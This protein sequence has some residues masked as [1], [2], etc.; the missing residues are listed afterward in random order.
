MMATLAFN[1]S[2]T[3]YTVPDKTENNNDNDAVGGKGD[4]TYDFKDDD[5]KNGKKTSPA[6]IL[7]GANSTL[8]SGRL[9]LDWVT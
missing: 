9:N 6:M 5:A 8:A 7:S 1:K 4:T 2:N 3:I